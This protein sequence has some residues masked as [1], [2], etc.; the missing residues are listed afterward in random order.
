MIAYAFFIDSIIG[1]LT[2]KTNYPTLF[3]MKQLIVIF[4]L[5]LP[6]STYAKT[7]LNYETD[8]EKCDKQFEHDMDRNLTAAEMIAATDSRVVCYES[9]AHKIID[10]YYSKQSKIM[11]INLRDSIMAYKKTANNM[12]NPDRCYNECGNLTALM[13]YDPTLD[14]VKNYIKHLTDAINSNF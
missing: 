6:I 8:I 1:C 5:V 14:F 3:L 13:A 9:V 4:L 11:K 10:K 7:A 12:Y 2:D